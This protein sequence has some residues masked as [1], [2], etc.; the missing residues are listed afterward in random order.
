MLWNT[1]DIKIIDIK[2]KN[3]YEYKKTYR[4]FSCKDKESKKICKESRL[5]NERVYKI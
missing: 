1:T 2:N 5:D 4:Y 3:T